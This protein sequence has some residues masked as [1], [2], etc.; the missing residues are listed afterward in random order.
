MMEGRIDGVRE[1]ERHGGKQTLLIL[2]SQNDL[3]NT[4]VF[5]NNKKG[6]GSLGKSL[7]SIPLKVYY[8]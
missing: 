8:S 3:M 1:E 6:T 7:T 4:T 5:N 2:T